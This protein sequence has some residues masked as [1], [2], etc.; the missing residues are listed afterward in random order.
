MKKPGK[1]PKQRLVVFCCE[2]S[3]AKAAES[4]AGDPMLKGVEFVRVPCAG[5]VEIRHILK[6]IEAGAAV[7][8][9]ACPLDNC[10]YI[11]GNRRTLKRVDRVKQ[12]LK[13]AGIEEGRVRM[14]FLSSV[15][16][17]K[18]VNVIKEAKRP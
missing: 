2:N 7:L 11:H 4:A 1:R 18:L 5:R 15:D 8:A 9:L 6:R 14:E 17:H 16:P 10:K 13:D 3:A 12:V